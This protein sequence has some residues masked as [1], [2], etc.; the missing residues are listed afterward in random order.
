M[1]WSISKERKST[2]P[3]L[4]SPFLTHFSINI[5]NR[6]HYFQ[7]EKIIKTELF[8]KSFAMNSWISRAKGTTQK[9]THR[10]YPSQY[11]LISKNKNIQKISNERKPT[12]MITRKIDPKS[13]AFL[14]R[15]FIVF[16]ITIAYFTLCRCNRDQNVLQT[17][18]HADLW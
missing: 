3:Y 8:P 14:S 10:S 16:K 4:R 18:I 12:Q 9:L 17:T 11:S 1:R 6:Y 7:V 5:S 2:F 15:I 13:F